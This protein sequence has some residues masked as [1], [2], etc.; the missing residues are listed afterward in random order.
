MARLLKQLLRYVSPCLPRM[1]SPQHAACAARALAAWD[2]ATSPA[3][4]PATHPYQ[5]T[6]YLSSTL[7]QA[8]S[9]G[10]CRQAAAAA[11]RAE[12]ER[13]PLCG[14]CCCR[15]RVDDLY[16][17]NPRAVTCLRPRPGNGVRL[18]GGGPGALPLRGRSRCDWPR[19][20]PSVH[21][22][23]SLRSLPRWPL[24]RRPGDLS[25]SS[26][27]SSCPFADVPHLLTLLAGLVHSE[28]SLSRLP[29]RAERLASDLRSAAPTAACPACGHRSAGPGA[30]PLPF[31]REAF[32]RPESARSVRARQSQP[33]PERRER[34]PSVALRLL[35]RTVDGSFVWPVVC[36]T[37][38]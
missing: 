23:S 1:L 36:T 18:P 14:A 10:G 12:R 17:S 6:Q 8:G 35:L 3:P 9:I 25:C 28:L 27:L 21:L 38:V 33:Q 13:L 37:C 34:W 16:I 11:S 15:R 22:P 32:T 24:G 4:Q 30:L 5:L 7:W 20:E 31:G 26:S 29:Q 19:L 2:P